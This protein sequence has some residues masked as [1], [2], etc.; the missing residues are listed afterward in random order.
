M[1]ISD[2]GK[3]QILGPEGIIRAGG[4]ATV[5]H[6]VSGCVCELMYMCTSVGQGGIHLAYLGAGL[7]C[8]A[9]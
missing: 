2:F 8:T 9:T 3:S 1:Q 4:Y 6:M 7:D 5:T